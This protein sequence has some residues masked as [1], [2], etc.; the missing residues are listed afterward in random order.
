MKIKFISRKKRRDLEAKLATLDEN[1]AEAKEIRR[2]LGW[3]EPIP[4][5]VPEPPAPKAAPVKK[6]PAKKA[7]AK[8]AAPKKKTPAKKAAPKKKAEE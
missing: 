5:P 6:T 1:S 4:E 2:Q 7:P 3:G 8:K